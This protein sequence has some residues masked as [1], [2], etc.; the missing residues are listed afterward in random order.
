MNH[1]GASPPQS[2]LSAQTPVQGHSLHTWYVLATG[3][4]VA[5]SICVYLGLRDDVWQAWAV[6]ATLG[7][8]GLCALYSIRLNKQGRSLLAFKVMISAMLISVLLTS[9]LIADIVLLCGLLLI[10]LILSTMPQTLPPLHMRRAVFASVVVSILVALIDIWEPP[11][12]YALPEIV[13]WAML[14]VG[15]AALLRIVT[16]IRQFKSLSLYPTSNEHLQQEMPERHMRERHSQVS[17]GQTA[18]AIRNAQSFESAAQRARELAT[19]HQVSL[20]L[21]ANLELRAVLNA[22]LDASVKLLVGS[23]SPQIFLYDPKTDSLTFGAALGP[24][25]PS[26]RPVV[27]PRPDG[28]IHN[29]ARC[30][31]MRTIDDLSQHPYFGKSGLNWHGMSAVVP[32]KIG[33]RV[34]GVMSIFHPLHGGIGAQEQHIL[35]LLADQAA[36][37]IE[38]ANLYAESNRL[39]TFNENIIQGIDEGILI[40]DT[41]LR[42]SFANPKAA[43]LLDYTVEELVGKPATEL[44]HPE[45]FAQMQSKFGGRSLDT[46][47]RFE[48][49]LVRNDGRQAPVLVSLQRLARV[50]VLVVLTDITDR[51]QAEQALRESEAKLRAIVDNTTDMIYIKDREGRYVLINPAGMQSAGL[52]HEQIIGKNDAELWGQATSATY[53]E[54]DA[55]VM[56]RGQPFTFEWHKTDQD[57]RRIYLATKYPYLSNQGELIGVV[58]ISRDI[59]ELKRAE[60]SL[61]QTQKLE[62][63]GILAGGV[64]HDFNNLLVAILGQASLLRRKLPSDSPYLAHIEKA[65]KAAERAATLAGK[66]LAYSGRGHFEIEPLHI[67]ELIEENLHLFAAAIS[68]GTEL[69][70]H[71]SQAL[72]LIQ[73]DAGEMQQVIM[74]LILNAAEAIGNKPGVIDIS[75]NTVLLEPGDARL[76]TV[77]GASLPPGH[78][79]LLRV[80]DN[81][82]G[83]DAETLTRIFDPFFT[84]KFTGRG[85]G[86]SAVLGIVRGHKGGLQVE[87]T[88]G[89]GTVFQLIF[90]INEGETMAQSASALPPTYPGEPIHATLLIID[91]EAPVREAVT[92]ILEL[93]GLRVLGAQDGEAGIR[94]Y[95]TH[96]AEIDL[97]LLDHSMPGLNGEQT[98]EQLKQIDPNVKVILSSG[99]R[100]EDIASEFADRGFAGFIQKPY[101]AAAL[102]DAVRRHLRQGPS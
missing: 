64:A 81:G 21:T 22:I 40:I 83:M 15:L 4:W 18:V 80:K 31:Q 56:S 93:E 19:L 79:I 38:N 101:S 1:L 27:E 55:Y 6:A 47:E 99:Y 2:S 89:K 41:Q 46:S 77:T 86:L 34:V 75:T 45:Y 12:K 52:T 8:A 61:R 28:V 14:W 60:E 51:K 57:P 24:D 9:T 53:H 66:M 70:S 54:S 102:I 69:R 76:Q 42:I 85:L 87:S 49:T 29:V 91:D 59:T 20:S 72:P 84:T 32:L 13:T 73:A 92:D 50:G 97:I 96:R 11:M 39:R 10:S 63:L 33:Q 74:N 98:L 7:A 16:T 23:H 94:L 17:A 5:M 26:D 44:T 88:L 95:R 65:V 58:G 78:Y 82:I 30:A 36:I 37:A 35:Q 62:S 3:N 90:P 48:T 100:K 71:L 68:K 25:G 43:Q 67:N